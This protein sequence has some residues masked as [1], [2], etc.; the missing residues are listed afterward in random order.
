VKLDLV[1]AIPMSH[2]NINTRSVVVHRMS[3]ASANA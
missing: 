3:G 1:V 2:E